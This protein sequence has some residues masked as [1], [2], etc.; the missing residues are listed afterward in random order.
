MY[1]HNN[2]QTPGVVFN[3]HGPRPNRVYN[4]AN[5]SLALSHEYKGDND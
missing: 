2:W 4:Y 1:L 3:F 5:K